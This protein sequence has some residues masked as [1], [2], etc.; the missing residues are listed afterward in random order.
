MINSPPLLFP[1]SFILIGI[2][3]LS[4]IYEE[5]SGRLPV[6]GSVFEFVACHEGSRGNQGSTGNV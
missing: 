1:C 4:G 2:H 5:S 3:C 6:S